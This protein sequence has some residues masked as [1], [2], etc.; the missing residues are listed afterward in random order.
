MWRDVIAQ[1]RGFVRRRIADP[2][3]ADDLVGDILLR[4]HQ[5]LDSLDDRERLAQWVGRIARNAVIDEYRRA[6]R[7]REHGVAA[8]VDVVAD[9]DDS[10]TVLDELARCM[11]PLLEGLPPE[12]RRAVETI[13]LDGMPQADA[14]RGAAGRVARAMLFSHPRRPR[15]AHGLRAHR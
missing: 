10:S 1:L 6:G 11:R 5:N 9:P 15:T 8:L 12:Q 13:D 3:R 2:E 4:I 7:A 14:A